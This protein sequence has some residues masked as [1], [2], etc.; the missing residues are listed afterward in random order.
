[1]RIKFIL[2]RVGLLRLRNKVK[3]DH[4]ANPPFGRIR[5]RTGLCIPEMLRPGY[6][7]G[8]AI[9]SLATISFGKL[10]ITHLA[11]RSA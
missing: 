8:E 2:F 1:M 10:Q 3:S 5:T 4:Q 6:C 11:P 9:A 7:R